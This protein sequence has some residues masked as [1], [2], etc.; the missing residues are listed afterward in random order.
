MRGTS[1]CTNIALDGGLKRVEQHIGKSGTAL[2]RQGE[3]LG[4]ENRRCTPI[5]R[6]W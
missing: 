1:P 6:D 5:W 3:Q 4:L 2:F